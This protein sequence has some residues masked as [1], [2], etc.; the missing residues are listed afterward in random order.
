[1]IVNA[2][3]Q[4]NNITT[5]PLIGDLLKSK[6]TQEELKSNIEGNIFRRNKTF[7]KTKSK[8]TGATKE[9]S[10]QRVTVRHKDEILTEVATNFAH[11]TNTMSSPVNFVGDDNFEK[12]DNCNNLLDE[13]NM[14]ADNNAEENKRKGEELFSS[15]NI[16]DTIKLI[17][18]NPA[19]F[20]HTSKIL[21]ELGQLAQSNPMVSDNTKDKEIMKDLKKSEQERQT[22]MN[23]TEEVERMIKETKLN[24]GNQGV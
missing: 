16:I 18:N 15:D 14:D 10:S 5:T 23:F 4:E 22:L 12:G 8:P 11:I 6:F 20:K 7:T 9:K 21:R 13:D 3:N 19:K 24:K 1:M 17:S 2:F